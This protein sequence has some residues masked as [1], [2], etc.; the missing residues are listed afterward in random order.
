MVGATRLALCGSFSEC[1]PVLHVGFGDDGRDEDAG[2]VDQE[3]VFDAVDFLGAVERGPAIGDGLSVDES[4]TGP[5]GRRRRPD[6]VRSLPRT[7]VSSLVQVPVRH[8]RGKCLCAAD[9]LTVKS[10]GSCRRA[11]PVRST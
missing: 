3:V 2:G 10:C 5:V 8:Q 11:H 6:R 4:T 9:Q 7:A 1:G